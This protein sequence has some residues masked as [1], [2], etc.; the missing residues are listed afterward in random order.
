MTP[1]ILNIPGFGIH[2]VTISKVKGRRKH[3]RVRILLVFP[4]LFGG[5][6]PGKAKLTGSWRMRNAPHAP[7]LCCTLLVGRPT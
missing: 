6:D 3:L 4:N 1:F 5:A 2:D 7:S